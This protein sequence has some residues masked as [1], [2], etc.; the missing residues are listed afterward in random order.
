[1]KEWWLRLSNQQSIR[2]VLTSRFFSG[3]LVVLTSWGMFFALLWPQLLFFNEHGLQAGWV[4][5]W[6]DWAAHITYANVFALKPPALWLSPHPIYLFAPFTYPFVADAISG[7]LMRAGWS[8]VDAMIVPSI[9]TT[10]F[11]LFMVYSLYWVVFKKASRAV[12]ALTLFLCNGGWGVYWFLKDWLTDPS[13]SSLLYPAIEMTHQTDQ[14]I[15]W[16]NIVTSEMIPQRAFL[17]GFPLTIAIIMALYRWSERLF[18]N[19]PWWQLIGL[20]LL[21]GSLVFIHVHSLLALF[22]VCVVLSLRQWRQKVT[23]PA[24]IVYAV[25]TAAVALPITWFFHHN[26]AASFIQWLPGWFANP[27]EHDMNWLWFWWVNYGLFFPLALQGT[28]RQRLYRHPL[29]ISGWLIF[30]AANLWQFQPHVWDNTKVV[31]WAHLFLVIPVLAELDSW[32]GQVIWRKLVV[33]VI[34]LLIVLS[35]MID[36][37]RL[38][39]I[40]QHTFQM[41][42]T[43]ELVMA[44]ELN[45]VSQP[46]QHV[47]VGQNHDSWVVAHTHLQTL[48]GYPGWLWTYGIT[49]GQLSADIATMYRGGEPAE[50]LL[51]QYQIV[52][53][54]IGPVEKKD[55]QVNEVWFRERY[56]VVV[57][58]QSLAV[59]QVRAGTGEPR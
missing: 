17:L 40:D 26:Q 56:P 59:Y 22:L 8:L 38:T 30:L 24:W 49:D 7:L 39:Q 57:S 28:W 18:R 19:V 27:R 50:E 41:W 51:D 4:S 34:F 16:I 52:Y 46:G 55:F 12:I 37:W 36:I 31:T 15:E 33:G 25:A 42:R 11:F 45:A 10:L 20:G 1:M 21:S 3:Y 29:V 6:G 53:V 13:W 23:W 44:A 14:A 2:K 54:V 48:M 35:G 5:I 58:G 32:W 43:D 47:L 9:V